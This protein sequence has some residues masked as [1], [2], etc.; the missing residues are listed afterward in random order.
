[1]RISYFQTSPFQAW[2]LNTLDEYTLRLANSWIFSD[3]YIFTGAPKIVSQSDVWNVLLGLLIFAWLF[4]GLGVAYRTWSPD[5][6]IIF[7]DDH[8]FISKYF[9]PEGHLCSEM[10]TVR[11]DCEPLRVWMKL[12]FRQWFGQGWGRKPLNQCFIF[13]AIQFWQGKQRFE[14]CRNSKRCHHVHCNRETSGL[15]KHMF[16]EI[17]CP[18]HQRCWH[19]CSLY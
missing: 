4:R 2:S 11:M 17:R 13:S 5:L 7:G 19:S 9:E 3:I 18:Y 8:L 1:M 15:L 14:P 10:T 6:I 12:K 16:K